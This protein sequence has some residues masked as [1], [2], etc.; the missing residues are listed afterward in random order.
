[1]KKYFL[2]LVAIAAAMLF[3]TSC[4][5]S[6][7]EPQI[8][9]PT[10][11]SVQLPDQMG[12]KAAPIGSAANVTDLYYEVYSNGSRI[13]K[14]ST[15]LATTGA[16]NVELSLIQ[17]QSYDIYFWAQNEGAYNVDDLTSIPIHNANHNTELRAA[18]FHVEKNFVPSGT[19]TPIVLVRPFSQL[20]LGAT[21]LSTTVENFSLKKSSVTVKGVATKFNTYD[22]VGEGTQDL[23]FDYADVPD[24]TLEVSN[25][26]SNNSY[27]YISMDY[28]AVSG[29]E[30]ALVE[31]VANIESEDGKEI[32]H[33]FTNVPVQE[34]YRTNIIG[35]LISSTTDFQIT[36]DDDFV[37]DENGN[38]I[39]NKYHVVDNVQA[40][41]DVLAAGE[42]YVAI[43][44]IKNGETIT[45]HN[46]AEYYLQIPAVDAKLNIVGDQAT[47]VYIT[48]V[49]DNS[50]VNG[51][52]LNI[53]TPSATVTVSKVG[54]PKVKK[55][56][57]KTAQNTLILEGIVVDDI[58]VNGGNVILDNS[59]VETVTKSDSNTD[60]TTE[61]VLSN[62]S[63]I[64][65]EVSDNITKTDVS[66]IDTAEKLKTAIEK[67]SEVVLDQDLTISAKVSVIKD[68]VINGNGKTITYKGSERVFDVPSSSN[69][70]NV[71]FKDITIV[72][73]SGYAER[74]IN[75]NTNGKLI[76]EDVKILENTDVNAF[77]YAIN[78]PGSSDN[79]E[80][81]IKNSVI[82]G[83][84]ALNVWGEDVIVNAEGTEFHSL[85]FAEQEGYA[86]V[87]LNNDGSTSAERSVIN[88]KGGKIIAKDENGK[89]SSATSNATG[90]GKI[91]ID[92]STEVVGKVYIPVAV[93]TYEGATQF[94]SCETL[95]AAI[96]KA[97]ET[98]AKSVRLIADIELT[99]KVTIAKD[100]NIL[101]DLN[102]KTIVG[103]DE[104]ETSF[105]LITNTGNLNISGEGKISLSATNNRKWN[106][107]SSVISNNP[108]G[109]LVV[110]SGVVIEHLGG[111]DMAY[112]IDNLTNGKGTSA[113]TTING[114]TVKSTYRAIRQFLNGIE[115]TNEL[116]V[117]AGSTILNT[118]GT[119]KG[120]WM[121]DPSKNANTGKLVVAEGAHVDD[122]YLSVTEGSKEWPVEVSIAS[123]SLNQGKT[124][125]SS[126]V[127]EGYEVAEV[128][129]V[130]KVIEYVS[131]STAE[132][133]VAA[134][135][136]GQNVVFAN[137]I[138]IAATEGG[139]KKAGILQ[140]KAQTINGAGYTLTVT[141]AGGTWDC[142]IYTNGGII[143][144]LTVAG[145]MRG[146]FTAGQS[147]DLYIE[148]V[149]FKNVIYTFNSDGKM[150]DNPFGVYVSKSTINGWTSHSDMHTEVVYT[151]CSFGEGSGYAFCRPYGKTAFVECTFSAGYTIDETKTNEI[152]FT[153]CTWEE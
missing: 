84:I 134:L 111:T 70:A 85:D 143:K 6:I 65:G 153:D 103:V 53:E 20:N 67:L 149:E 137:N 43:N 81:E 100:A 129:G 33:T 40:A 86:A 15:K 130:W 56:T 147:S 51:I 38:I 104:A 66:K 136:A 76:L 148:N 50:A 102:G 131:V 5:E 12:T 77:T 55:I 79:A 3:A 39:D 57:S 34:N 32:N 135:K 10:T 69:G 1:M 16:T 45:L 30:K 62:G 98:N 87:K 101:L 127:P 139:Y 105:G 13:I 115:A 132:D 99:E 144:N 123:S 8:E 29:D 126:N 95:Q 90:T 94:Y 112:G 11:F 145:A 17:D 26:G 93:V 109:N 22:G 41:N 121:Q 140:N 58:V 21:T 146:I 78:L 110:E 35:N 128:G 36:I 19:S 152:T 89:P 7:V 141:G 60:T 83:N 82:K 27:H 122:V 96:D 71:T 9:G 59:R 54:N 118:T 48:L 44:Y 80:V 74:G 97:I 120:I 133:L 24:A 46:A 142:A 151:N 108:G 150:P 18:F 124:V 37:A 107:Y 73:G 2:S 25:N 28:F 23:V 42:T 117:N 119:N 75:Y 138:T 106:A 61:V 49:E 72:L 116:Y 113:I 64:T 47:K 63:E 88:I 31:V 125:M 92:P 14:A 68:V 4:Q 52:E 91:N 114:A